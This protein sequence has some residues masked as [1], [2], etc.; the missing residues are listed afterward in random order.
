[1]RHN[2]LLGILGVLLALGA[3]GASL[4]GP[5]EG[6]L[7]RLPGDAN[8]LVMINVEKGRNSTFAKT[9]RE[10]GRITAELDGELVSSPNIERIVMASKL[11]LESLTPV[12]DVALISTAIEPTVQELADHL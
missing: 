3:V 12:W 8:A 7:A 4:A 9:A 6:H 11:D 2:R 1:M 10:E 5:F